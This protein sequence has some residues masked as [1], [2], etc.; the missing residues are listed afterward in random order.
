MPDD[1]QLGNQVTVHWYV[2]WYVTLTTKNQHL[3]NQ[4]APKNQ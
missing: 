3:G 4:L 2:R 1:S